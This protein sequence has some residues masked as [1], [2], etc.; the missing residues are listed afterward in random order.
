[1]LIAMVSLTGAPGPDSDASYVR[2]V[3]MLGSVHY[4]KPAEGASS[5][6]LSLAP[7][8]FLEDTSARTNLALYPDRP[9]TLSC[10]SSRSLDMRKVTV[11]YSTSTFASS[12]LNF[13]QLTYEWLYPVM[14]KKRKPITRLKWQGV[15]MTLNRQG[16]PVIWEALND[17]HQRQVLFVA[18]SLEDKARSQFT[19][20]C[21]G[22]RFVIEPSVEAAPETVVA[23]VIEDGP[24]PMGPSVYLLQGHRDVA[25]ILCRCM[26]P[27]STN[28]LTTSHYELAPRPQDWP[29]TLS[30]LQTALPLNQALRVLPD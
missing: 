1:M 3:Q 14:E 30:K 17:S 29:A 20:A 4:L 27:H 8:L 2:A 19:N 26:P 6:A 25:S 7:L 12:N 24:V 5:L 13:P 11:Y 10:D 9:G 21:P 22:R 18:Q 28:V 23:R 15:R 16:N